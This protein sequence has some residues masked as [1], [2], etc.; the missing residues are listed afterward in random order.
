MLYIVSGIKPWVDTSRHLCRPLSQF[1]MFV[2]AALLEVN[3]VQLGI[4]RIWPM[5]TTRNDTFTSRKP[6]L[7]ILEDA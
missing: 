4:S 1:V 3:W 7:R 6:N 5:F 2:K